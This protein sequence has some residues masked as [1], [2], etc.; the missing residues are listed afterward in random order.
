MA[1]VAIEHELARAHSQADWFR[2]LVG[3]DVAEYDRP[4]GVL[5]ARRL[6][7]RLSGSIVARSRRH[8]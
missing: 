7:P 8:S 6:V 1:Q 5:A 4:R 3:D 2:K